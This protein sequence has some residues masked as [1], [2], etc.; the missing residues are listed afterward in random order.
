MAQLDAETLV[1]GFMTEHPMCVNASTSVS[2]LAGLLNWDEISGVP[3]VDDQDRVIGVVSQTDLIRALLDGQ[4]EAGTEEDLYQVFDGLSDRWEG[5]SDH[6]SLR[7]Q[8]I[9]SGDPV[10]AR[11]SD[12][13]FE[14]ASRMAANKVHRVI[15]VD[16]SERP[17]GIVS[18][19]DLM[20]VLA[21]LLK[22]DS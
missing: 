9:M 21:N 11:P 16:E 7:V 22:K 8:D 18:T 12:T 3:V 2:E 6:S 13:V 20:P 4:R 5:W 14:A 19:L 10:T 15:V 17:V 1:G